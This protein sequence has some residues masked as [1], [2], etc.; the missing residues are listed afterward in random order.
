LRWPHGRA[1]EEVPPDL[2]A[3]AD[4]VSATRSSG[5]GVREKRD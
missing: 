4:S 5:V 2:D 3:A 1:S